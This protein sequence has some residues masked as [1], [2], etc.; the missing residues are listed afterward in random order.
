[1]GLQ[2]QSPGRRS[3]SSK[4]TRCAIFVT[5]KLPEHTTVHWHGQRLPNGMDGVGGLT[6]PQ[7]PPGKTFVYEFEA[8]RSGT[9]MYH[10]HADEMV[11]MAMGMMGSGSRT[12]RI[13]EDPRLCAGGPRLRVPAQRLRHRAR[14]RDAE[15][16]D[17]A[18]LQPLVLE[19]PRLPRH[20]QRWRCGWATACASASAT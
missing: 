1:V 6:Q 9:F 15:D 13:P 7:I 3:R 20:R 8:R 10:P 16:H 19:Q 11:Q 17:D 2:R 14:Q 4:A 5:N 12:R 18:R